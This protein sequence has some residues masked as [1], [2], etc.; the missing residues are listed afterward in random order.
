LMCLQQ[1]LLTPSSASAP[2]VGL[3]LST[4]HS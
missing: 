4:P 3:L 1:L 2:P